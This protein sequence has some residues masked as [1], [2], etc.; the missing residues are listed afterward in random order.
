MKQLKL[1]EMEQKLADLIWDNEPMTSKELTQLCEKA[2]DWK[3]TTTYTM[4]K[5]LC[6]RDIFKNESGVVSSI[7]SKGEFVALQGEEFLKETFDSSL[8]KFLVA[9]TS[10]NK[11]SKKEIE[12]LQQIIDE[13]REG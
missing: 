4:L 13:H 7:M 3:R 1:G 2:F 12:E 10:R 11:L 8:P 5:R 6:T 9:F